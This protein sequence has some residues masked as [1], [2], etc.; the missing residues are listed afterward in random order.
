MASKGGTPLHPLILH[1]LD[2]PERYDFVQALRIL[3]RFDLISSPTTFQLPSEAGQKSGILSA[4]FITQ[5]NL[6]FPTTVISKGATNDQRLLTFTISTF[7]LIGPIGALPY[8][9]SAIVSNEIQKKNYS[10]KSF[11]DIFQNRSVSLFYGACT[12]YRLILAYERR[13]KSHG[14]DFRTSID[15]LNGLN[16]RYLRK[17]LDIDDDIVAYFTGFFSSQKRNP[18][19]LENILTEILGVPIRFLPFKGYWINIIDNDKSALSNNLS[20]NAFNILGINCIIGSK[21]WASQNSFRLYVGPVNMKK[22][23]RFFPEEVFF[24][25][26]KSIVSLYCGEQY[27]FE[28]KILLEKASVPFTK[29]KNSENNQDASILGRNTWLLS[30]ES[31]IDRDDATCICD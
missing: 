24:L 8:S 31:V 9:Y 29:L 26:I 3:E 10:L 25:T 18:A 2:N 21:V 6:I 1:V 7:G 17:R 13:E 15:A 23:I 14:D 12:K 4:R 30:H 20:L 22:F 16:S 27:R 11:I 19:G 5:N 28:I